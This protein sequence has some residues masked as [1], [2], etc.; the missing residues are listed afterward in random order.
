MQAT[1]GH[2]LHRLG[3]D[4]LGGTAR[5]LVVSP[6]GAVF[7]LTGSD[8]TLALTRFDPESWTSIATR[9]LA[10]YGTFETLAL[11]GDDPV[12]PGLETG[13]GSISR[14]GADDLLPRWKSTAAT[15]L[16][17]AYRPR[18]FISPNGPVL[19]Y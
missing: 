4:A 3:V 17:S 18:L 9:P 16:S 19:I 13:R 10:S 8:S 15:A 12:V 14:F 6:S 11:L 2:L 5:D 1:D 7:L